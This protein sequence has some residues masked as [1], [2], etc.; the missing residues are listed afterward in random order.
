MAGEQTQRAR[1]KTCGNGFSGHF[2][3]L[4][5]VIRWIEHLHTMHPIRELHRLASPAPKPQC[6]TWDG[7]HL[8]MGSMETHFVHQLAPGTLESCRQVKAPGLPFGMVWTGSDFLVLCGETDEDLR[9]IRRL[10]PEH[11]FD[12]H[13]ALPC[14]D[15]TGSQ[16]SWAGGGI[17]TISQWY[18]R[19]VLFMDV[20][21]TVHRSLTAPHGI[22][23]HTIAGDDLWVV[24]TDAEEGTEYFLSRARL[25]A[26][27]PVFEDVASVPFQ[28]RGLTWDGSCLWT[29]H[30]AA[31]RIV[32]FTPWEFPTPSAAAR[33]DS[34][35][36][37]R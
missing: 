15:D 11:G 6:L 22:C 34:P 27:E 33:R 18:R 13:F 21:G 26:P 23:G 17:F 32:A 4:D 25:S 5:E 1:I 36:S 30:R 35:D 12:P 7:Q 16:M 28:A 10:D 9:I 29:N 19:K 37:R 8:W 14:P 3:R 2:L 31:H 24:G 20:S